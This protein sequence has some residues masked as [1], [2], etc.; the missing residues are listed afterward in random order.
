M[1]GMIVF[2]D[3]NPTINNYQLQPGDLIGAFYQDDLGEMKC[4]GADFWTGDENIIFPIFGNDPETPEKDGFD[5]AETMQFKVFSQ[6][7]QKDYLVS[8]ISWDSEY[9]SSDKWY[10]MGLSA[11]T[12]LSCAITFDAYIAASE[13]PACVGHEITLTA[14]LFAG[15]F[16]N[17]SFFVVVGA[18]RFFIESGGCYSFA[19]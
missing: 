12:E 18:R 4:A 15:A 9:P 1:H 3:A 7:T 2:L 5:F 16:E 8:I 17:L 11:M 13:N 19:Q 6:L 10:P 14:T